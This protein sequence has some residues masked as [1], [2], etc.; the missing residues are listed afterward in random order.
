MNGMGAVFFLILTTVIP[1]IPIYIMFKARNYG[2]IRLLLYL[3]AGLI[4]VL[5]AGIIQSLFPPPD[6]RSGMGSIIFGVFIRISLIEELSRLLTL[7]LLFRIPYSRIPLPSFTSIESSIEHSKDFFGAPCGLAAGLG[8]AAGESIFYGLTDL[9]TA[10]LRIFTA[11]PLHAACGA[12]IGTALSILHKEPLRAI[13][14]IITAILI[15]GMYNFFIWSPGIPW[16]L[17]G[18]V[19]LSA[20]GSSLLAIKHENS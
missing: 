10:F 7:F 17:P 15:H 6:I 13:T 14:L 11:A 20:L 12:R 16:F 5:T 8:F 1:I 9:S 2:R 18:L 3:A 19:A 4:A